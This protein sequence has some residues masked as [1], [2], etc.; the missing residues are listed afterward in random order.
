M[1]SCSIEH[2]MIRSV[3]K[4]EITGEVILGCKGL[5]ADRLTINGGQDLDEVFLHIELVPPSNRA[6]AQRSGLISLPGVAGTL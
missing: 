2:L 5:H 6:Q 1:V 3:A 4:A